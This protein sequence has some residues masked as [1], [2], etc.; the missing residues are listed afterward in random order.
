M[1]ITETGASYVS[2]VSPNNSVDLFL[3]V[4]FWPTSTKDCS[5]D[6]LSKDHQT[7]HVTHICL[8]ILFIVS[9]EIRYYFGIVV[10]NLCDLQQWF[11]DKILFQSF[12]TTVS[13]CLSPW[14][15]KI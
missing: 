3:G 2:E 12:P 7:T 1:G 11:T 6:E 8:K 14:V 13:T 15:M 5:E 4:Q 9:V 10:E